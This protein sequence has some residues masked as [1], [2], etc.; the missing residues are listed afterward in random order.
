MEPWCGPASV[1]DTVSN[2]SM[3]KATYDP[4]AYSYTQCR[5]PIGANSWAPIISIIFVHGLQGH[6]FRTWAAP[7]RKVKDHE[8]TGTSRNS[9]TTDVADA[10]QRAETKGSTRKKLLN[11]FRPRSIASSGRAAPRTEGIEPLGTATLA[12][13]SSSLNGNFDNSSHYYWPRE[14]LPKFCPGARILTWGYDSHVTKGFNGPVNKSSVYQHGKDLLYGL[15]R[16]GPAPRPMIIVAHSL[17]GIVTKEMLALSQNS[18]EDRIKAIVETMEAVV[19]LGTPHRGSP[20]AKLGDSVSRIVRSLGLDTSSVLLDTLGLKTSDLQ[21]SQEAFSAVWHNNS[22]RVKTFQEGQGLMG[23][24]IGPLNDKVVDD[25][26]SSLGDEREHAE[27]LNANHR[28]MCRFSEPRDPELVKIM[29]ELADICNFP[30]DLNSDKRSKSEL[31]QATGIIRG[32][33]AKDTVQGR[34]LPDVD[35]RESQLLQSLSFPG[36]H[37]ASRPWSTSGE[38]EWLFEQPEFKNWCNE[39]GDLAT[40]PILW[41]KGNPGSG[42]STAMREAVHRLSS[43]TQL[44]HIN[45]A[46]FF[47]DSQGN[48]LLRSPSGL[49]RSLLFQLLPKNHQAMTRAVSRYQ[50]K[51]ADRYSMPDTWNQEH[52]SHMFQDLFVYPSSPTMIL[53]DAMDECG[54]IENTRWLTELFHDLVS[55]DGVQLSICLSTRHHSAI[56]LTGIEYV[57]AELANESDIQRY[58]DK[59]LTRYQRQKEEFMELGQ[60]IKDL[61]RGIFLWVV[62]VTQYLIKHIVRGRRSCSFLEEKLV[63][64]PEPLLEL[65]VNLVTGAEDLDTTTRVLRWA[66]LAKPLTL[67]DWR[68]LLPFLHEQSKY[69]SFVECEKS[70]FWAGNDEYLADMICHLSMGLVRIFQNPASPILCSNDLPAGGVSNCSKSSL[71]GLAGSLDYLHGDTRLVSVIHSSV[72]EFFNLNS[73]YLGQ[74]GGIGEGH[75]DIMHTVLRLIDV[76]DLDELLEAR[77]KQGSAGSS[78]NFA[79][80]FDNEARLDGSRSIR[81]FSS[82]GTA[83]RRRDLH[84]EEPKSDL[85]LFIAAED[86]DSTSDEEQFRLKLLLDEDTMSEIPMPVLANPSIDLKADGNN[87]LRTLPAWPDILNYAI[88]ELG[89]HAKEAQKHNGNATSVIQMLS[90]ENETRWRRWKCLGE[91]N[92]R[93]TRLEVWAAIE[94]L[95]SWVEY[96][97][98]NERPFRNPRRHYADADNALFIKPADELEIAL[99]DENYLGPEYAEWISPFHTAVGLQDTISSITT[100]ITDHIVDNPQVP[101]TV[102]QSIKPL[103]SSHSTTAIQQIN[104]V[105]NG[106]A[107]NRRGDN[108]KRAL[109]LGNV[110]FGFQRPIVMTVK[111]DQ[112]MKR[113]WQFA[114]ND[115]LAVEGENLRAKKIFVAF[116]QR[117]ERL[118][119]TLKETG[120]RTRS[121]QMLLAYDGARHAFYPDVDKALDEEASTNFRVKLFSLADLIMLSHDS[122]H[123]HIG[124]FADGVEELAGMFKDLSERASPDVRQTVD[125]G[126]NG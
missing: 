101:P 71:G 9:P 93:N 110:T 86:Q 82:A 10:S 66:V 45:F 21:R 18:S 27:V 46:S 119:K 115:T 68:Y 57:V 19:F 28:D 90:G 118:F 55:R 20:M 56:F 73:G 12:V 117:L 50:L 114:A 54:G 43:D 79:D 85:S 112:D 2:S 49:F 96:L 60:K 15:R 107:T 13:D 23:A 39:N 41:I 24:N 31:Y 29:A 116:A 52:L 102:R 47:F 11:I 95:H 104:N 121:M 62:L 34:A 92:P 7:R 42:K 5:S 106:I 97:N 78:A 37:E 67:R 109:V 3:V 30:V 105:P 84:K 76:E 122:G 35:E 59:S 123:T 91:Y 83:R 80:L 113:L 72:A 6:P 1:T 36:L 103:F 88:S 8:E 87:L 111:L 61:S 16:L 69:L 22:L 124:H 33:T 125:D 48:E 58:I 51:L 17:G 53:I 98:A 100:D 40:H 25:I 75:V 70:E 38:C 65:Y 89:F 108:R 94:G 120:N 74:K 64:L 81:S 32:V 99:Y 26:S 14:A 77:F 126:A 4:S 44:G 63:R